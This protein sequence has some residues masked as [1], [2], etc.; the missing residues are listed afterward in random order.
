MSDTRSG[1]SRHDRSTDF[2]QGRRIINVPPTESKLISGRSAAPGDPTFDQNF[3]MTQNTFA[4]AGSTVHD[5]SSRLRTPHFDHAHATSASLKGGLGKQINTRGDD[6][7]NIANA[8][9]RQENTNMSIRESYDQGD[10]VGHGRRQQT[11]NS[12]LNRSNAH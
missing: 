6:L 11:N 10:A 8:A 7:H 5:P 4:R 1:L 3:G 12:A 2:G 9:R